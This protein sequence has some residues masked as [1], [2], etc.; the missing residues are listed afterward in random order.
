MTDKYLKDSN[1]ANA[2]TDAN[3]YDSALKMERKDEG[4][5]G[6]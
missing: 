3:Y 4:P 2:K 5:S 1:Y 6:D